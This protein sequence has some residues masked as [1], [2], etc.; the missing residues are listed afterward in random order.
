MENKSKNNQIRDYVVK[1]IIKGDLKSGDKFY[2]KDFIINKFR[3]NPSYVE[4]TY[5]RLL[6]ENLIEA[7]SDYYYMK[8]DQDRKNSLKDE[9]ANLIL[10]DYLN[11]MNKIGFDNFEAFEFL[12]KRIN[13]NG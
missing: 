4:R 6:D 1:N 5:K 3:V 10:N 7:R 8:F 9:F 2:E 11:S 12:R 13:S